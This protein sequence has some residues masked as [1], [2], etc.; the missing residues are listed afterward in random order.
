MRFGG[1]LKYLLT[2]SCLVTLSN[3]RITLSGFPVPVFDDVVI[4]NH[5]SARSIEWILPQLK[6]IIVVSEDDYWD[7]RGPEWFL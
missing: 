2:G 4:V 1:L 5:S 3:F 7:V 6:A